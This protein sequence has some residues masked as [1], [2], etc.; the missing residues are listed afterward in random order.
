VLPARLLDE[1]PTARHLRTLVV[2][3]V[4]PGRSLTSDAKP[5]LVGINHVALEVGDIEQALDF[6][7]RIFEFTLRGRSEHA[8][9]ID[10][11]DQNE[12]ARREL[13]DKGMAE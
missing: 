4:E 6:Y 11:G 8:A 13:A 12:N 7:G 1:I 9:F 5:R 3:T 10:I 2:A